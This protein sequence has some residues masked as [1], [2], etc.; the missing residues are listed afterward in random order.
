MKQ[1]LASLIASTRRRL[2]AAKPHS[3]ARIELELKL[4]DLMTKQLRREI[5]QD[6]AA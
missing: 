6:K 3:R 1:S 4:R 2:A 5:R